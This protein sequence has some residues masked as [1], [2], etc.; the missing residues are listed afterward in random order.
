MEQISAREF[1]EH[2]KE[3]QADILPTNNT[4]YARIAR[5]A[6]RIIA[7]NKDL[8]EISKK[9]WTITVIDDPQKN[10]FVLPVSR[11]P[12]I[13][14]SKIYLIH[15]YILF[16]TGNIFVYTG[17]LDVCANDDQLGIILGHEMSHA[18]LNHSAESIS[19]GNLFRYYHPNALS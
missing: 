16:Q 8:G 12:L 5:V 14:V 13:N 2:L 3:N 11:T 10:A 17:M 18:I 6:H 1:E 4:S 9:E 7:A 15:L 19:H